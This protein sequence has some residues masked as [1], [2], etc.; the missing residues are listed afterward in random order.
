MPGPRSSV[1]ESRTTVHP[2]L[3][4]VERASFASSMNYLRRLRETFGDPPEHDGTSP[5]VPAIPPRA[6]YGRAGMGVSLR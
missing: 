4:P 6:S 5:P 1:S 3:P 2:Q